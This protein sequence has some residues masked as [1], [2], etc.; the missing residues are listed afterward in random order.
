MLK[1]PNKQDLDD[2]LSSYV[3]NYTHIQRYSHIDNRQCLRQLQRMIHGS[4]FDIVHRLRKVYEIV[5]SVIFVCGIVYCNE[6]GLFESHRM[7]FTKVNCIILVTKNVKPEWLKWN[8]LVM[9]SYEAQYSCK[10]PF[11][12]PSLKQLTNFTTNHAHLINN[13]S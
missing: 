7:L 10:F 11:Q 4:Y 9:K 13:S 6:V 12:V 5:H 2:L 3:Y 8:I 1:P